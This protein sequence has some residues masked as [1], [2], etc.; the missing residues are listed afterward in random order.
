MDL[1]RAEIN[2]NGSVRRLDCASV[3]VSL[4]PGN[5]VEGG[6]TNLYLRL[7]AP[8]SRSD[9]DTTQWTPLLGPSG[10]TQFSVAA[11]LTGRGEWL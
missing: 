5:E 8:G 11:G 4:F 6:P 3:V 2:A 9:A 1:I 7:R 10:P